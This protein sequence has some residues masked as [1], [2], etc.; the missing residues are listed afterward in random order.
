MSMYWTGKVGGPDG[1][2]FSFFVSWVSTQDSFVVHDGGYII[3]SRT[4]SGT[5]R[6]WVTQE[7]MESLMEHDPSVLRISLRAITAEPELQLEPLPRP[8]HLDWDNTPLI[9][10]KEDFIELLRRNFRV[11]S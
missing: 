9:G 7:T 10:P 8:L 5:H 1:E 3:V 4:G 2:D 11:R 6:L